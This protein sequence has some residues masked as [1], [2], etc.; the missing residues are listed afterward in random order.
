MNALRAYLVKH[1]G[2]AADAD[3]AAVRK[4]AGEKLTAS[5]ILELTTSDVATKSPIEALAEK[6]G[7]VFKAK[8]GDGAQTATVVQDGKTVSAPAPEA[9]A[10]NKAAMELLVKMGLGKPAPDSTVKPEDLF[11]AAAKAAG[12]NSGTVRIPKP[13]ERYESTKSR[14]V[15]PSKGV[16][17]RKTDHPMAGMDAVMPDGRPAYALSEREKALSGVFLMARALGGYNKQGSLPD[18]HKQ[19]YEESL[20]ECEFVGDI[21]LPGHKPEYINTPR[22]LTE[23]EVKTLLAD[24]TSGG[25]N[26]VPYQFDDELVTFPLLYNELFPEITVEDVDGTNQV[27][28]GRILNMSIASGPSEDGATNIALLSTASLIDKLT[29]NM[30]PATGAVNFGRDFLSDSPTQLLPTCMKLYQPALGKW[31]DDKIAT[32]SGTGEPTGVTTTSG[33]NT[34]SFTNGS[35]GPMKVS[36]W[37]GMMSAVPPEYQRLPGSRWIWLAQNAM[38]WRIRGLSVG[39]SD[40]RRIYGY[41]DLNYKFYN[42]PFKINASVPAATVAYFNAADYVMKRRKG[43]YFETTTEGQTLM[44]LNEL[45]V[46]AR[47]RWGGQMIRPKSAALATNASVHS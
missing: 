41:D 21:H 32:G 45:M 15:F 35:A 31:L 13:T 36:D 2:L 3:E 18:W 24:S 23:L 7:D 11:A 30:Y 20:R 44:L 14:L 1:F 37:E 10:V 28:Q 33:T 4:L 40:Q 27:I 38:W 25:T 42:M 46:I 43:L 5:Q 39:T 19:A 22:K 47:S 8:G 29:W 17:G 12:D 6:L 16:G 9:D 26:I 34:Y